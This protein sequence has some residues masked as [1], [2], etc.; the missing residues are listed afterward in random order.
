M[1]I[2]IVC[3]HHIDAR[4]EL[5]CKLLTEIDITS[6]TKPKPRTPVTGHTCD[7][8]DERRFNLIYARCIDKTFRYKIYLRKQPS[9]KRNNQLSQW[10]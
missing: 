6:L 8:A 5:H 2:I 10:H 3:N 9:F 4:P 7:D 1:V